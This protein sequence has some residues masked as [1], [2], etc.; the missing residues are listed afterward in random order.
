MSDRPLTTVILAM[1]ADGKI[2]D[3]V[4]SPILF[5][6]PQDKT[7]LEQQVAAADAVITGAGTFRV[8]GTAMRILNPDLMAQREREGK[9]PQPVQIVASASGNLDRNIP[10]FQQPISRWLLTTPTGAEPWQNHPG[11]DKI[12]ATQTPSGS[13]DWH[14]ALQQIA[15]LGIKKLAILGGGNLVAS[16]LAEDLIDE[17]WLTICPL[18]LGGS[19]APTPVDG[20]GF[21]TQTAPRLELLEVKTIDAEV[22]LHYRLRRQQESTSPRS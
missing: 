9:P 6:S 5:G 21:S 2:S 4:R 18:L 3:S 17:L 8:K 12:L 1:S 20:S 15:N 22:F 11:F 13:V 10:F 7:H 14:D 19:A 16:L